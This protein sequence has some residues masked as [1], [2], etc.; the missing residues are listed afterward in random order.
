MKLP[1]KV[2][3]VFSKYSKDWHY[4]LS[5]VDMTS[6]G[7]VLAKEAEVEFEPLGEE[8]LRQETVKGLREKKQKI[9][10][11]AEQEAAAVQ[12]QIDE[13]L[14]LEAPKDEFIEL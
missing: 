11:E 3:A 5:E 8:L 4:S 1:I 13:L 2:F 7:W 12:E 10:V 9:Y 14:A 6:E